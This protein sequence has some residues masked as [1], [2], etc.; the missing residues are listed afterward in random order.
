MAR[1]C[2]FCCALLLALALPAARPLAAANTGWR[3]VRPE[4]GG[5]TCEMPGE[6]TKASQMVSTPAGPINVVMYTYEVP[7]GAYV[8]SATP[9][10]RNAPAASAQQRLDGARD[11]AV[12]NVNGKLLEEKQ[13]KVDNY[14]GRELLVKGPQGVFIRERVFMVG[15]RLIQAVAVSPS[16][17]QTADMSHF[18]N[19]I[20]LSKN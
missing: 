15:D 11:G 13:I 9:I 3:V 2:R 7:T 12:K 14:P 8:V 10:P 1:S 19:S 18:F 20:K 6:P 4:G 5:I 17:T 16:Q